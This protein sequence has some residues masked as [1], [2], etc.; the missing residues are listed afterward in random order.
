M[1]R[2]GALSALLLALSVPAAIAQQA[3]PNKPVRV[4]VPYAP[5]GSSSIFTRAVTDKLAERLGQSF[6]IDNRGGAGGNIGVDVIAKAPPDGYTI[7]LGV[8]ATQA[9]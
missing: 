2:L 5:G 9:I 7:G 3:Y 1:N 6:V 8:I 4:I